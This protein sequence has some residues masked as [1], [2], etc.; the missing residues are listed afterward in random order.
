M[1]YTYTTCATDT[2]NMSA[3]FGAI[4]DMFVQNIRDIGWT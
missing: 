4:S 3:V 1:M 2:G